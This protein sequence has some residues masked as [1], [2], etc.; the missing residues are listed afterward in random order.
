[1]GTFLRLLHVLSAILIIG[2]LAV[3]PLHGLRGLRDRDVVTVREAGKAATR[4]GFASILVAVLG[5][6]L[7]KYLKYRTGTPWIVIAATLYIVLVVIVLFWTA[8]A[9]RKA[10]RTIEAGTFELPAPPEGADQPATPEM[11]AATGSYLTTKSEV[12]KA[13][14]RVGAAAG[15]TLLLVVAIVTLMVSRPFG[16]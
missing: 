9:L 6:I 4:L 16:R 11:M 1:M 10:A 14:G 15:V 8:P 7:A 12:D 5:G 2:P 3:I 13:V